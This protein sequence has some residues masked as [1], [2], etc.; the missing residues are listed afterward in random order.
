VFSGTDA[1]T[2]YRNRDR[3]G[4]GLRSLDVIGRLYFA[5]AAG[6]EGLAQDS[7]GER[8]IGMAKNISF[9]SFIQLM[10]RG[11][12]ATCYLSIGTGQPGGAPRTLL[13]A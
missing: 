5:E 11:I 4:P 12:R 8:R 2:Y 1:A 7:P 13:L 9:R 3:G 6:P 10:F